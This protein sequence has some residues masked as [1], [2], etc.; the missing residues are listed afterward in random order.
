MVL[1]GQYLERATLIVRTPATADESGITLEGLYHRGNL[2]PA[3]VVC[4]P[5][6]RMGGSMDS[7]VVAELAWALT[8]FGHATLRFNYEGVGA[9]E[10]PLATGPTEALSQA[11]QSLA[12]LIGEAEDAAVAVQHLSESVEHGRVGV[13]GYSFGAAVA[14]SLALKTPS[15]SHLV[16]I[17]PPMSLFDFDELAQ[18]TQPTLVVAGHRDTWV[19]HPRLAE[20]AVG[21]PNVTWE[22][23]PHADHTF[24]RGLTD[25]GRIVGAWL[26]AAR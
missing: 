18:V 8:R 24:S 4:A 1:A 17:A 21:H 11:P 16:L 22:V 26:N 25:L 12:T 14:L 15:V 2:A 3:M 20:L 6:P 19:D 9:S 10:G 13:A 23:I 5:H 7:P